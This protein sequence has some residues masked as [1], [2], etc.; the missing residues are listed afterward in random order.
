MLRI[1]LIIRY[2]KAVP[3]GLRIPGLTQI[4]DVFPT[5]L[6][7]AGI[8]TAPPDLHGQSLSPLSDASTGRQEVVAVFEGYLSELLKQT[9]ERAGRDDLLRKLAMPAEMIR[10]RNW[11]LI[12]D[13]EGRCRLFDLSADPDER[14]DLAD[15]RP[16]IVSRLSSQLAACLA[17]TGPRKEGREAKPTDEDVLNELRRFGYKA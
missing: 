17:A 15:A 13:H 1:P 7:L 5:L 8:E 2:P 16:L 11:K 6:D 10:Q 3:A 14:V 12:R 9:L 4:T